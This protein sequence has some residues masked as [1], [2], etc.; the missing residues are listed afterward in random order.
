MFSLAELPELVGFFS[1]SRRDDE[2]SG[3]AL[4]RLRARIYDDLR[5]QLGRDVRLWQ[6]T[7]AIPHGTL[8]GDEIKRAIAES[9][10]FI[11][12]VTPSAVASSHCRTEF[13]LFLAREAELGRKDLIFPILYIRVP[14]LG[15]EE[16]RRR[17]DVLEII[18]ARQYAD[19]T[20][21]R[22]L[23]I[24]SFEVGKQI[25]DFCQDIVEALRKP[26]VSPEERRRQEEAEARERA[27]NE[28]RQQ[29]T[30][31]QR[32]AE[33]EARRKKDEAEV[34]RLAE[35][36]R[37][38]EAF[39][40]V[41]RAD[42][43]SAVDEFLAAYPDSHLAAEANTLRAML[44]AREEAF[45][46]AIASDDPAVLKA[47]LQAY[48]KGVQ[49]DEARR[50]LRSLESRQAWQP[51]RRGLVTACVFGVVVVGSVGVWLADI[52]L[53]PVSIE[54]PPVQ[55][56]PASGSPAPEATPAQPRIRPFRLQP[57]SGGAVVLSPARERALK[58]SDSFKECD[59]CPEMMV[60]PVGSFTMG[61]P[62]REQGR[63]L[64]ESQ[65]RVTIAK[66]FAVGRF[67]VTFSEWDA[68][69]ADGG[70]NGYKPA[71]Q[72]WGRDRRPVINVS[73]DDTK[74]YL[75]WLSR[76]TG[77]PYRLLSEAEFEYAARASTTT[78]Y[79]WRDEIGKGN[80]NCNGCGSQ[81]DGK[82]TAPVGS[83]AAN[84]FGLYDMAGNVW[85]WC[86]DAWHDNY[87]GAPT[88]G[89][90]WL[91]GGEDSR[92]VLRGVPGKTIL[93]TSASAAPPSSGTTASGSVSGGRLRFESLPLYLLGSRGAAPCRYVV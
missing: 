43:V 61:S 10:F 7:A 86:E 91:Q 70:C 59:K 60:V 65:H 9:A 85:E 69:V 22:L 71:D 33:N 66:P 21:I 51:S 76:K 93:R 35:E 26:W 50:R 52:R 80:A 41:K 53:T 30:E 81:W 42:V 75:A 89:S 45:K 73:W 87:N 17:N 28:R 19:W 48:P 29:E 18:H 46:R 14:A 6:D 13:E 31:A 34:Q 23:D 16:D 84:A 54:T 27:E 90:A 20:K 57:V 44:V 64:D 72:G 40:K 68:C 25:A 36:R 8:W 82:Q 4:S 3:G 63:S 32:R 5:L 67:A 88:D 74:T 12:I 24:A 1:Y 2:H 39:A 78:A 58:P 49:T 62:D 37:Q 92:R 79:Y 38:Q 15:I 11:P 55:S 56:P 83:F 47:F 77:K